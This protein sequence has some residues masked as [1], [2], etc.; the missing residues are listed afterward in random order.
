MKRPRNAVVRVR[1]RL[2]FFPATL[3]VAYGVD[4]RRVAG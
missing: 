1:R 3:I 2:L 4:D